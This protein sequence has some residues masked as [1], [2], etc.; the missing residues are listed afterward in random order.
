MRIIFLGP[1]GIGKGTQAKLLCNRHYLVHLSTG[2]M[3]RDAITKN[4]QI[5]KKASSYMHAGKLVPDTLVWEICKEHLDENRGNDFVLD[6][7]PRTV[8]QADWLDTYML[9]HPGPI[10]QVICLDVPH[11]V[12]IER[13]SKRRI[14]KITGE[15]YHLDFKPPPADIPPELIIQRR[16]DRPEAVAHRL[17]VYDAETMP[18]KDHYETLGWLFNVDGVGSIDDVHSRIN[19]TLLQD[20]HASYRTS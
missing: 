7:Y 15:S 12:I 18:V 4:N 3:L 5:G 16:D 1:P 11:S 17:D 13:L 19:E 2:D 6:G 8:Q 20:E 14:H 10:A 9:D